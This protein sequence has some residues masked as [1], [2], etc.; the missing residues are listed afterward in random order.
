MCL[1]D[2]IHSLLLGL[3]IIKTSFYFYFFRLLFTDSYWSYCWCVKKYAFR[4]NCMTATGKHK[5]KLHTILLSMKGDFSVGVLIHP[6]YCTCR[7]L[8]INQLKNPF[9]INIIWISCLTYF[10]VSC[11]PNTLLMWAL[12]CVEF[13]LS[14]LFQ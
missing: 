8:N 13:V 14:K 12:S 7:Y 1:S 3:E 4:M 9:Q 6:T 5:K 2:V 11:R 10:T